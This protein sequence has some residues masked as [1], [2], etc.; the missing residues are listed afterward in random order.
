V[1]TT[2]RTASKR[3]RRPATAGCLTGILE[4]S[5]AVTIH[6]GMAGGQFRSGPGHTERLVG[7]R[8]FEFAID[9]KKS[10]VGIL[11]C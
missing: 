5:R 11:F 3:E 9:S 8:V 7:G 1:G 4:A 2:Q 10:G 6:I